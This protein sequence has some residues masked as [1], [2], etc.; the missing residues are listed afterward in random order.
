MLSPSSDPPVD[1][2]CEAL[3]QAA[4][5]CRRNADVMVAVDGVAHRLSGFHAKMA[6]RSPLALWTVPGSEGAVSPRGTVPW[7]P[8]EDA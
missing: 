2:R 7:T 8:E 5:P 1:T 3:T 4:V 6:R